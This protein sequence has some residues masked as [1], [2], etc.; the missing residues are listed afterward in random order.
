MVSGNGL[1]VSGPLPISV[2]GLTI[3]SKAGSILESVQFEIAAGEQVGLVG[4]SGSGKSTLS[5]ALLGHV[6]PGLQLVG[7]DIQVGETQV[8][9]DGRLAK[10]SQIR[11]LRRRIGRLDQDP[12]ASLTPTHKLGRA[13]TELVNGAR[14]DLD[15][16]RRKALELVGLPTDNEFLHR[17]PG[18]VSGGQ[19]RRVALAR[20]LLRRPG[21]LILDEPTA[22]LDLETKD[23]V[24][25]LITKVVAELDATLLVI[26]HDRAVSDA[27]TDRRLRVCDY[28]VI[29][30][31]HD[32]HH[33]SFAEAQNV[34]EKTQKVPRPSE[35]HDGSLTETGG[36]NGEVH[37]DPESAIH[38]PDCLFEDCEDF[39]VCQGRHSEHHVETVQLASKQPADSPPVLTVTDLAAGAPR[40]PDPVVRGLSFEI[41][42]QQALAMTGNS[43][44][45]KSTVARTLVGLWPRRDGQVLLGSQ[46]VPAKLKDWPSELRGKIGWVP[47]DPATSINSALRLGVTMRR[48]A[49][50]AT[51]KS[52][53]IPTIDEAIEMVGLPKDWADR[54]PRQLSGG[55][56]QRF[57]IARALVGG[58]KVLILDEVTSSLDVATRN[59]L[60]EVLVQLKQQIPL[61]VTTH[62]PEVVERVCDSE[63]V[64]GG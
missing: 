41:H 46:T 48:A 56:L 55:Q 24:V 19:R 52:N 25:E 45:G 1:N 39:E 60:C 43:G 8:I 57:A 18:E 38:H 36:D 62:D 26:T 50:R 16:K 59:G 4:L 15:A 21:L 14:T 40:L 11:R 53:G 63:I 13:L 47:Q 5:F 28:Q 42:Q 23:L 33:S 61:L 10:P 20:T 58:A 44:C 31:H 49:N 3:R 32:S 2:N 12:A 54:F 34:G 37:Q 9:S 29:C 22:G 6:A 64:L 27:L 35:N 7:G 17:Y 51:A 30:D